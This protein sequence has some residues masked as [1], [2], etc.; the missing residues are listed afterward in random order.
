ME[1]LHSNMDFGSAFKKVFSP[2]I[3]MSLLTEQKTSK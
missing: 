3:I 1:G 2:P